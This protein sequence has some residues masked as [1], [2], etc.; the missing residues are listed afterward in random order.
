MRS[1]EQKAVLVE[2]MSRLNHIEALV[3][4]IWSVHGLLTAGFS[5]FLHIHRIKHTFYSARAIIDQDTRTNQREDPF[6]RA[7]K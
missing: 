1:L 6:V 5:F 2:F 3:D 7:E 4:L